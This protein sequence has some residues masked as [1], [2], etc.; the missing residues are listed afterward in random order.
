MKKDEAPKAAFVKRLPE[1]SRIIMLAA[2][3]EPQTEPSKLS[4]KKEGGGGSEE[5][6]RMAERKV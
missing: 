6:A 5:T 1:E 3:E 2:L 4:L